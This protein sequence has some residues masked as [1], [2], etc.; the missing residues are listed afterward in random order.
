MNQV[1]V[2]LTLETS[3]PDHRG[4]VVEDLKANG[5]RVELVG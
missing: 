2:V 3:D 1:E 4:A 5:Y